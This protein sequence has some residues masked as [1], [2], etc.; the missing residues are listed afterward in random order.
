MAVF[1]LHRVVSSFAPSVLVMLSPDTLSHSPIIKTGID[2]FGGGTGGIGSHGTSMYSSSYDT[3]GW[4]ITT[5]KP[6]TPSAPEPAASVVPNRGD[7][8]P[9]PGSDYLGA[10]GYDGPL[11]ASDGS[12]NLGGAL[13]PLGSIDYSR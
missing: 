11:S 6:L 12:S 5:M 1:T 9:L 7:F 2:V 10:N 3:A 8:G 4:R 13:Q